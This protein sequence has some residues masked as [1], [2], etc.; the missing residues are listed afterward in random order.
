MYCSSSVISSAY[1]QQV[2]AAEVPE[3]PL[4]SCSNWLA[5]CQNSLAYFGKLEFMLVLKL[6]SL[7]QFT[8]KMGLFLVVI[9]TRQLRFMICTLNHFLSHLC[10]KLELQWLSW[11]WFFG[12]RLHGCQRRKGEE[13]RSWCTQCSFSTSWILIFNEYCICTLHF[14]RTGGILQCLLHKWHFIHDNLKTRL[15]C[16]KPPLFLIVLLRV[17]VREIA[18]SSVLH[19]RCDQL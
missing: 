5:L 15:W 13:Q 14:L 10:L 11:E 8:L 6:T 4:S 12:Y 2:Y 18:V 16:N 19:N 3:I 7:K 17:K 1:Q 9:I